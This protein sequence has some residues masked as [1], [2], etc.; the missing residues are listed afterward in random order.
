MTFTMKIMKHCCKK[1]NK[2]YINRKTFWFSENG[3]QYYYKGNTTQIQVE[4]QWNPYQN[5]SYV[6]KDNL[7]LKLVWKCKTPWIAKTILKKNKAGRLSLPT[8][9]TDYKATVTNT[10][11]QLQKN[12][13][14]EQ[15]GRTESPKIHL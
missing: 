12:R 6:Q 13:H 15:W 5:F 7:I 9:H 1:L 14:R 11:R 4:I 2:M 3:K 10:T 8:F